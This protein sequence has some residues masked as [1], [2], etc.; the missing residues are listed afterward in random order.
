M[1]MFAHKIAS[2]ATQYKFIYNSTYDGGVQLQI[3]MDH[4]QDIDYA[5]PIIR[6]AYTMASAPEEVS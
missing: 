5:M 3:Q 2:D 6:R 4:E 1:A